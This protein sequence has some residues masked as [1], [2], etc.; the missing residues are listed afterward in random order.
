MNRF[1]NWFCGSAFWRVITERKLLPWMISGYS[2]G[3]HVLEVGAGPGAITLE[4]RRRAHRVTSLEYDSAFAA[5][6]GARENGRNAAILQA[7]ATTLPFADKTFSSVVAILV[8]HHLHSREQ[9][10]RAFAEFHRVLRPAGVLFAFEI[11]D[12]RLQRLG[13]KKST[14]VPIA[15]SS[16][17]A[18]LGLAGFSKVAVDFQRSAFR[19]CA[20]RARE[21]AV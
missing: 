14:F 1:E 2:L 5:R 15:P 17:F 4:L 10:D 16:A 6:L 21:A 13:H 7:D 18:R 3:D 8:L 11:Q 9:Q 12:G 20:L 19:I